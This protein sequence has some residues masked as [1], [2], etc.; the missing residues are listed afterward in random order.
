MLRMCLH[1]W[2]AF[3]DTDMAMPEFIGG[4]FGRRRITL[5]TFARQE[6]QTCSAQ[7]IRRL[8]GSPA[9]ATPGPFWEG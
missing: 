3:N 6:L 4:Y 2:K 7:W 5:D 8:S 9:G 1:L